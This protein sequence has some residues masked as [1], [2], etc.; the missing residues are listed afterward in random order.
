MSLRNS[1]RSSRARVLRLLILW[2]SY[3]EENPNVEHLGSVCTHRNTKT[4]RIG[5]DVYFKD[6]GHYH[7]LFV[8]KGW[9][10][11]ALLTKLFSPY[12]TFISCMLSL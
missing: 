3:S 8:I 5:E 4:Q 6:L 2:Q 9:L 11:P 7:Y 10:C 1:I 12:F